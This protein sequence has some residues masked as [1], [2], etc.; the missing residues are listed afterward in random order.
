ML[1]IFDRQYLESSARYSWQMELTCTSSLV[2]AIISIHLVLADNRWETVPCKCNRKIPFGAPDES[3]SKTCNLGTMIYSFLFLYWRTSKAKKM[4]DQTS[5]SQ[6]FKVL[7]VEKRKH[8][9][10]WFWTN[11]E[12]KTSLDLKLLLLNP[13]EKWHNHI[14]FLW[15]ELF[16]SNHLLN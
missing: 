16:S 3:C 13:L 12:T 10:Q 9:W 1:I 11:T 15:E 5:S 7:E 4:E 8:L 2:W 14:E 6:I